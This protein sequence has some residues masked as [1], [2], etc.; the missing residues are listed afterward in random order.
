MEIFK[1]GQKL[2][3]E[4]KLL[5]EPDVFLPLFI[6]LFDGVTHGSVGRSVLVESMS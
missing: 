4:L 5:F 3:Q 2:L 6:N 1:F